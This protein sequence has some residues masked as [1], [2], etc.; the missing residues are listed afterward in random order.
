MLSFSGCASTG[1]PAEVSAAP[2]ALAVPAASPAPVTVKDLAPAARGAAPAAPSEKKRVPLFVIERSI[3]TNVAHYDAQLAPDGKLDPK[4]PVAAY[5]IMSDE[6][7]RT[8]EFT[9]VEKFRAYGFT[10]EQSPSGNTYKMTL[11]AASDRP[12]LIKQDGDGVHAEGLINGRPAVMEKIYVKLDGGVL[13]PEV[14]SVELYG[15]NVQTGERS[16]E[17]VLPK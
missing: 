5:W 11:A 12:L 9:M 8:E 15:R 1:K 6:D 3:N 13:G 2:A 4:E 14:K 17:I 16:S 10:I 7:G